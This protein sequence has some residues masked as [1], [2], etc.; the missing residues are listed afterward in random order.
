MHAYRQSTLYFRDKKT[1]KRI[2]D[3]AILLKF[4]PI[5]VHFRPYVDMRDCKY[6][7]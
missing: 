1:H 2:P 3:L 4:K 7:S 5:I 6:S